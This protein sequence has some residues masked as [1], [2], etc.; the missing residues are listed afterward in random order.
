[1]AR[2][3]EPQIYLPFAQAPMGDFDVVLASRAPATQLE[4]A[5]RRIVR[6]I[7]ADTPVRRIRPLTE[8][9]AVSVAQPRLYMLLLGMFAAL[10]LVLAAVGVYGVLSYAVSLRTRELGVRMALGADVRD[11]TRL[12]LR[13]GLTLTAT[14]VVAGALAALWSTRLLRGLLHEVSPTDPIALLSGMLVL[15]AV[16][17]VACYLPARRAARVDP[18]IAMRAE[19]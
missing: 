7:A 2:E 9:L 13:D 10:A 11:V 1:V 16:A 4:P 19:S 12:V 14:G 6:D 5:V 8:L 18:V 15:A 17:L 3:P